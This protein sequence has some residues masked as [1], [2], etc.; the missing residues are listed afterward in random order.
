MNFDLMFL[1]MSGQRFYSFNSKFYSPNSKTLEIKQKRLSESTC[2]KR[3]SWPKK[4][5]KTAYFRGYVRE[6]F[7]K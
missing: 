2:Y 1:G 3:L 4:K 7:V 6:C 5:K